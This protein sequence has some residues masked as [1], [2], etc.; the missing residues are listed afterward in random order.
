[1]NSAA[2][3]SQN[4]ATRYI[5]TSTPSRSLWPMPAML[6]RAPLKH[7]CYAV[8]SQMHLTALEP[9][10]LGAIARQLHAICTPGGR[11]T[12]AAGCVHAAPQGSCSNDCTAGGRG[13]EHRNRIPG[14][15]SGPV[16]RRPDTGAA[17]NTSCSTQPHRSTLLPE[18]EQHEKYARIERKQNRELCAQ[19]D[20]WLPH[21]PSQSVSTQLTPTSSLPMSPC[22]HDAVHT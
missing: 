21:I 6:I 1:M 5:T 2:S 4:S 12:V 20:Q 7:G 14:R 3:V 16:P 15:L 10:F 8:L 19:L 13:D 18:Q 22:L 11:T 9:M 17:S